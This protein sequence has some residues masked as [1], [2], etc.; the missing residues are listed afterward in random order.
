MLVLISDGAGGA[1]TERLLGAYDGYAPRE[2]AGRIVQAAQ[3]R[4]ASDDMTAAV[5]RLERVQ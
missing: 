3:D 5:I 1:E 2:L 4:A